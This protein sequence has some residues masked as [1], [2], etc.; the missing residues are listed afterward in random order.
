VRKDLIV[1]AHGGP[2]AT[3]EDVDYILQH[4]EH[5]NGFYGASSVER[6]P[7]EKAIVEHIKTFKGLKSLT[8]KGGEKKW[9]ASM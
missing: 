7:V 5:C 3:P 8:E 4:S 1:I 6:L 2:I 9:R